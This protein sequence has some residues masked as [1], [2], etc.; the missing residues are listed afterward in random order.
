MEKVIATVVAGVVGI[1]AIIAGI[2]AYRKNCA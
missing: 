1:G 2:I